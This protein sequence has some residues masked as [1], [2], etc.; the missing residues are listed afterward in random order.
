MLLNE[1]FDVSNVVIVLAGEF[2]P[3]PPPVKY[4]TVNVVFDGAIP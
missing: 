3:T 1:E 4:R 2:E